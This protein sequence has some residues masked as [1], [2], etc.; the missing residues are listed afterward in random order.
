MQRSRSSPARKRRR[1]PRGADTIIFGGPIYTGLATPRTVEAVAV[2]GD[3]I[4]ATGAKSDM[5]RLRSKSTKTIDLQGAAMYPGFTD[6]HAHLLGIGMRELT[7]NLEGVSSIN[8]LVDIVSSAAQDAK[9]GETIYGRG[10]IE[11]GW[12]E[13]RFPNRQDL[14]QASTGHTI[15]LVRADGHALVVNSLALEKAGVTRDTKDPNGG[16]IERDASGEPTGMFIDN[17]MSLIAPLV[18]A[19]S[20]AQ[21][22]EAYEVGAKVYADYGWT[23]LHNMSVDPRDLPIIVDEARSGA[24][25]IRVYNAIDKE[26]FDDLATKA[27]E[28][29]ETGR[30]ITRAIK[31][32][33]DG[34]LGSRGAALDAPYSDQPST[35]GLLTLEHD[36]ALAIF[37]KALKDGVQVCVHAIGDRGNRLLLDWYAEAFAAVPPEERKVKEPRWR[38]EHSQILHV[39]DIPRFHELGVIASMQPSHAIGDF[40]FA[41]AR[42]GED[43]L[44]GAYAWES[45]LKS[46][47]I[48]TGGSD[49]PVERGDPRIEFYAAVA[50][51][52]LEGKSGPDW[53]P[54]EKV[55]RDQALAMFT[56]AP[57]YASFQED[58]LGAIEPGKKA[59][60]T[61]FSEDIMTIPE[62]EILKV[63]PVMTI[64]DGEIIAHG[65]A[66]E[67][68]DEGANG[69]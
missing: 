27:P 58:D 2:K 1:A 19:P 36:E 62:A 60:F 47:A 13:K 28:V 34:A 3:R 8:E 63:E 64:V 56:S 23:G 25:P 15:V 44:D 38:D 49:A 48:V 41:P 11:T 12:P 55:T 6:S 32:Y 26:G 54:E 33:M 52:D 18:A 53:R 9:D 69:D 30:V 46:G 39:A 21:K 29:D 66:D 17:A 10:W 43:R 57:A 61:V 35:D 42:L 5:L 51:K 22:R 65:D 4:L 67:D 37:K 24:I 14:D 59:D 7:L 68:E 20:E 16:R 40:Y 45:L 50:R 31:L